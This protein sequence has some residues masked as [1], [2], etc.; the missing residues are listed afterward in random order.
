MAAV[1][2]PSLTVAVEPAGFRGA[3]AEPADFL[4]TA[5]EPADF[6]RTSAAPADFLHATAEPATDILH[7]TVEPASFAAI[8]AAIFRRVVA[9]T[10]VEPAGPS[11]ACFSVSISLFLRMPQNPPKTATPVV[12]FIRLLTFMPLNISGQVMPSQKWI[13]STMACE[14]LA[15]VK[16]HRCPEC[17]TRSNSVT[18]GGHF[19]Q[20]AI[21]AAAR[22]SGHSPQSRTSQTERQI[23]PRCSHP[24]LSPAGT[25][26]AIWNRSCK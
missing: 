3:A 14:R 1:A 13:V 11:R 2:G 23:L 22:P 8:F 18:A 5:A 26:N 12:A 19:K 15:L 17:S 9:L 25:P 24:S 10:E 16:G 4:R 20:C 7:A 6:L 21:N